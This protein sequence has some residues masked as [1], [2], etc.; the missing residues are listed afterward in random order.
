MGRK[1]N[2]LREEYTIAYFGQR[3]YVDGQWRLI[4]EDKYDVIVEPA[5]YG[6]GTHKYRILK[7]GPGLT[8]DELVEICDRGGYNFGYRWERGNT[9]V[10]YI[11]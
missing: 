8:D 11:D 6:Y 4:D 1:Y 9:L 2:T 7:N 3:E 10:I 5:G